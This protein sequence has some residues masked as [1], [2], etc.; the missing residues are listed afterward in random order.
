MVM[1]TNIQCPKCKSYNTYTKDAYSEG[2]D[3]VCFDCHTFYKTGRAKINWENVKIFIIL[4]VIMTIVAYFL[5]VF[6]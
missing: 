1:K 2:N 5:G 6:E 4:F 3:I